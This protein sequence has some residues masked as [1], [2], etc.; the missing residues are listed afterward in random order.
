MD[1]FNNGIDLVDK[2]E[3]ENENRSVDT[4]NSEFAPKHFTRMSC[5]PIAVHNK[6]EE[7]NSFTKKA[8]AMEA[9]KRF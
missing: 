6:G 5:K 7:Q 1:P 9:R 4:D 3:N 2:N 8:P